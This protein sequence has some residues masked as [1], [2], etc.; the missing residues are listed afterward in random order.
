MSGSKQ[1]TTDPQWKPNARHS[2]PEVGT[3]RMRRSG[4][5]ITW[6]Q[7]PQE[8]IGLLVHAVTNAGAAI[9]FARTSDRGALCLKCFDDDNYVK[10][11]PT[12]TEEFDS[13]YDW[14]VRMFESD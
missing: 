4:V 2:K 8:K 7:I 13:L 1:S 6:D 12:T 9:L 10:E 11:Y 3:K 14:L 5:E